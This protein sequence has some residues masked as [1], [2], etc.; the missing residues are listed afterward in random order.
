MS[1]FND[2]YAVVVDP[3]VDL[4]FAVGSTGTTDNCTECCATLRAPAALVADDSPKECTASAASLR[5]QGRRRNRAARSAHVQRSLPPTGRG[6]HG[7]NECSATL[8][9]TARPLTTFLDA[10][11]LKIVDLLHRPVHAWRPCLAGRFGYWTV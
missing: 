3:L 6:W 5:P 10:L 1:V 2:H 11:F 7:G 9:M 8:N 4:V